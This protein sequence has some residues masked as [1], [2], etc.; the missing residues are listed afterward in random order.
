[1]RISD[2]SSDVC[3]SDLIDRHGPVPDLKRRVNDG[4]IVRH[5]VHQP[6]MLVVQ[7]VDPSEAGDSL[8]YHLFHRLLVA[9]VKIAGIRIF[10]DLSNDALRTFH[11]HVPDAIGSAHV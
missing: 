7:H 2:W 1:M 3:S 5:I 11:E 6:G 9:A 8:L 10:T 4:S